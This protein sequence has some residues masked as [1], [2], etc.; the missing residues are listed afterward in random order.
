MPASAQQRVVV[1]PAGADVAVPARGAAAPALVRAPRPRLGRGR[2]ASRGGPELAGGGEM[3]SGGATGLAVPAL[4]GLPLAAA[5]AAFVASSS[6]PG[7]GSGTSAPA[8]TR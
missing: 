7:A 5:A 3:L 2:G 4:I 6:V 1:V 8:R